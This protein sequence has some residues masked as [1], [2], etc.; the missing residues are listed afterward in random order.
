MSARILVIDQS[1]IVHQTVRLSLSDLAEITAMTDAAKAV[2]AEGPWDLAL[3]SSEYDAQ[4]PG[5][6]GSLRRSSPHMRL[7]VAV[8]VMKELA[9]DISSRLGP[10][11][12][13][14][15]PWVSR[16]FRGLV[17]RMLAEEAPEGASSADMANIPP[18]E[19]S[20]L[21]P[22][23]NEAGLESITSPPEIDDGDSPFA[24][25]VMDKGFDDGPS[26]QEFVDLVS[27]APE[28]VGDD[29][30]PIDD[31][32][33]PVM[34]EQEP[35]MGELESEAESI[36][37]D[38][39][40]GL[41]ALEASLG[42]LPPL[43]NATEPATMPPE[44]ARQA[45][46]L[47]DQVMEMTTPPSGELEELTPELTEE[48]SEPPAP[49]DESDVMAALPVEDIEAGFEPDNT[50]EKAALTEAADSEESEPPAWEHDGTGEFEL[51]DEHEEPHDA[52]ETNA[53]MIAA[54]N[55]LEEAAGL[56]EE[57]NGMG[58]PEAE[59]EPEVAAVAFVDSNEPTEA[60]EQSSALTAEQWI[61]LRA[62]MRDTVEA[63]IRELV[64]ELAEELIRDEIKRLTQGFDT[65]PPGDEPRL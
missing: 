25:T 4:L 2:E 35:P 50:G 62:E 56:V 49:L 34:E 65:T 29:L 53:S 57:A 16:E 63:M 3:V 38:L 41:S 1:R 61:A 9:P 17:E 22:A 24:G 10:C 23:L 15:K 27:T 26:T 11:E 64:P 18:P 48:A 45:P 59:A 20:S 6:I 7:I 8:G 40:A 60:P 28:A 30:P 55:A 19:E 39:D 33:P 44:V 36:A 21:P 37:S 51:L 46:G 13:V 31:D 58:G 12:I 14:R 43:E 5:L 42:D 47:S 52:E 32:M 54:L